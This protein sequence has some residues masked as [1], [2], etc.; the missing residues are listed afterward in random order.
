MKVLILEDMD[1]RNKWFRQALIGH[2]IHFAKTVL[3]AIEFLKVNQY[4]VI[5]LD[6]D[7]SEAH[8]MS[9][10][11]GTNIEVLEDTGAACAKWIV[12]NDNNPHAEIIV[13]SCNPIGSQN[14]FVILNK[15]GYNI[16][17]IPFLQLQK[18]LVLYEK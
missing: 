16:K 10:F 1:T 12:A 4:D 5:F 9:P 8:Y 14:I 2:N 3:E 11:H 15:E 7:L 6:H 17:Q 18:R 13:H